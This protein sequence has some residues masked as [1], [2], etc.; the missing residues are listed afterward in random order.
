MST[1]PCPFAVGDTLKRRDSSALAQK[2]R[3]TEVSADGCAQDFIKADVL[4]GE[5]TKDP[6]KV[7]RTGWF[8]YE[9][10]VEITEAE[11][12]GEV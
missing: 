9:K 2:I 11:M 6:L 8:L 5:N 3:V 4:E 1:A 7:F 12:T 10:I